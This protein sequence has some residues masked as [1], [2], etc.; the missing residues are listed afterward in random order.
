MNIPESVPN[1]LPIVKNEDFWFNDGNIVLLAG[2]FAF[3]I[4]RG[5]LRRHSE[6]FDGMFDI[7]QPN[8]QDTMEGCPSVEMTD[9]PDD[10]YHF[11]SALY[12]GLYPSFPRPTYFSRLAA[13]CRLS[14]KYLVS[15]LHQQCIERFSLDWPST[16]KGWDARETE[17]LGLQGCYSPR[18]YTPHPILM[19]DLS[20]EL[21][22]DKFLPSAFYDL[23]RYG[24]SKIMYGTQGNGSALSS[25]E[26]EPRFVCLSNQLF[27]RTLH[28]RERGQRFLLDFLANHVEKRRPSPRCLYTQ[29]PLH[30]SLLKSHPCIRAFQQ[31]YIDIFRSIGGV[32]IGRDADPLFTISQAMD[33]LTRPGT[34]E[35][36]RTK[37][38]IC[39]S[40]KVDFLVDCSRGREA[41][42]AC[43]P[44]W[45][46]LEEIVEG[47]GGS[48]TGTSN[49][50]S[51]DD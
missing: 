23:S 29:S 34:V 10:L 40:C 31:I 32:S 26:Q 11:L 27:V 2:S 33:R 45:F 17:A 49:G 16:L 13:V 22:L 46:G 3:K 14:T 5:Q 47:W 19:I 20:I 8:E 36:E 1:V 51:H 18:Q 7:P 44:G 21:H 4:H 50:D 12:D 41:A 25:P 24:P 15:H 37:A 42:W 43:I 39:G 6:F 9:S 38:F 35:D 48:G 28:G 30:P